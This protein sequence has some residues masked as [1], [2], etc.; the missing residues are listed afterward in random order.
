MDW[1]VLTTLLFAAPFLALA[2]VFAVAETC[3]IA[4][5]IRAER[6]R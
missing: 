6:N 3:A 2:V 4:A 1:K 5:Q